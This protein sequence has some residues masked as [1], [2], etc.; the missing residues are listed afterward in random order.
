[1]QTRACARCGKELSD[2][3][4]KEMG[5][6]PRCRGY[7]NTVLAKLMPSEPNEFE[8][9]IR[10]RGSWVSPIGA[11]KDFEEFLQMITSPALFKRADHRDVV[12]KA[13]I[14]LS[15]G[16]EYSF[17]SDI[18]RM[19]VALGYLA[20]VSVWEKEAAKGE[21]K[22]VLLDSPR[23]IEVSGP[24]PPAA[25]K[26]KFKNLGA[27]PKD[28]KEQVWR[29]YGNI[30]L[31][32]IER[33]VRCCYIALSSWPEI[34]DGTVLDAP[35]RRNPNGVCISRVEGNYLFLRCKYNGEFIAKL[36]ANVPINSRSWVSSAKEWK[37]NVPFHDAAMAIAEE[38]FG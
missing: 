15:Y 36:K 18:V 20:L 29:F 16:P 37:I 24:R 6:G 23:C 33:A 26:Q 13:E 31:P 5:I 38:I 19:T 12:R 1:M 28:R 3:A 22:A 17:R 10:A 21:A 2:P 32:E 27:I 30:S 11:E 4:S 14:L 25:A 8:M 7:D 9:A 34:P 35:P